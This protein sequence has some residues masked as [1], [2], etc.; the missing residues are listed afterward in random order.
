MR[1]DVWA[2]V[3]DSGEMAGML[4]VVAELRKLGVSVRLLAAGHALDKLKAEGHEYWDATDPAAVAAAQ[5]APRLLLATTAYQGG[6]GRDLIPL[7]RGKSKSV[8]LQSMWGG[9]AGWGQEHMPDYVITNDH[10]G[11]GVVTKL[12]PELALVSVY[13]TGFP[14]LDQYA[15]FDVIGER[16]KARQMLKLGDNKPLV[17]FAG[18]SDATGAMLAEL[19][20]VLNPY[21]D[22]I[23]FAPRPH[24]RMM[25]DYASE[26]ARWD[27]A[28]A[29]YRGRVV[30]TSQCSMMQLVAA[31]YPYGAVVSMY[32]T[33]LLEAAAARTAAIAMLYPEA[34]AA[35]R[36]ENPG[37]E[38]F[39][40]A[41]LECAWYAP[42][43]ASLEYAVS[44]ALARSNVRRP[45]Q[46]QHIVVDGQNARRAAD[47]VIGLLQ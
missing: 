11:E 37:L 40:L 29:S 13:K 8:L 18:Q 15:G 23:H 44:T 4:P 42:D 3:Q 26:A 47:V 33:V 16:A 2:T 43:R 35:F 12:W 22:H 7:L 36:K 19:V 27:K 17:V 30:D 39:P 24:P 38:Q 14:M 32:S 5:E 41:E 1:Y 10:V 6:A 46:M 21:C 20:E 9:L 34:L 25:R 45:Q 31:A 28:V